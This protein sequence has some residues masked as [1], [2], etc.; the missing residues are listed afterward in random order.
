MGAIGHRQG[1]QAVPTDT[2]RPR[3]A[4]QAHGG[5]GPSDDR[6]RQGPADE[7]MARGIFRRRS[8]RAPPREPGQESDAELAFPLEMQVRRYVEAGLA[9]DAARAKAL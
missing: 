4:A 2:G 7:L 5:M 3:T 1:R 9:P 8:H 6:G